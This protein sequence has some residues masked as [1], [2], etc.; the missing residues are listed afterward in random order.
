MSTVW[1][2]RVGPL[3]KV[4]VVVVVEY[5][6]ILI[7]FIVVVVHGPFSRVLFGCDYRVFAKDRVFFKL[8]LLCV[9]CPV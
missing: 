9:M 4:I 2:K 1:V 8:R 7:N 5:D 3:H 6:C